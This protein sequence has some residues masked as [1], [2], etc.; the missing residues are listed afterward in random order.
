MTAAIAKY[1][2]FGSMDELL[3][4]IFRRFFEGQDIHLGTL[5][6]EDLQPPIIIA[7][8]ERRSGTV[9]DSTEDHRFLMPAIFSVNTITA[10][11]DADEIGEELQ[12][13]CRLALIQA[14]QEQWV[15]PDA[16]VISTIENST[17]ATRVSD[18][19]TST[20]V[21][22]YAS[23]PK[24]WV[25]YESIYRVLYRPPQQS[26]ITNRFVRPGP[27]RRAS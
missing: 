1:P 13:A 6:T 11:V 2:V 9:A 10:G 8:R 24:H 15:I 26:T 18:W 7:R 14:Q 16:G 19:A 12:E 20:G 22:Q 23:L 21:V 25:R 17:V 27:A 5:F 3:L 4:G